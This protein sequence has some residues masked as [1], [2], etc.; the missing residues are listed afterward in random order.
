MT[1]ENSPIKKENKSR[2]RHGTSER[3]RRN[4]RMDNI[5]MTIR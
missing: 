1:K 2:R 3:K 5:G 4:K